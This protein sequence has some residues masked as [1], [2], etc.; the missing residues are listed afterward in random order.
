MLTIDYAD[1][2]LSIAFEGPLLA[3]VLR[4]PLTLDRARA[5]YRAAQKAFD[6]YKGKAASITI[7]EPS[8]ASSQPPEVRDVTTKLSKDFVLLGSAIVIEGSGF[9]A[10]TARTVIAGIYLLSKRPYPNKICASVAEGASFLSPI[11]S[12][13]ANDI[14][15]VAEQTRAALKA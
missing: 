2:G 10:A 3:N 7:V 15:Y 14:S 5:L 4:Q 12:R 1:A 9:A 11:L 6:L 13:N 8:A